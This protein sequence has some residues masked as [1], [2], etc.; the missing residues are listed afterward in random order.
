[1]FEFSPTAFTLLVQSMQKHLLKERNLRNPGYFVSQALQ[2]YCDG[3]T[4]YVHRA[5]VFAKTK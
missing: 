3:S 5:E 2:C 1:M 4:V